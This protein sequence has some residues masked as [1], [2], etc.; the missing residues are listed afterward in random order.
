MIAE[1]RNVQIEKIHLRYWVKLLDVIQRFKMVS[2]K[3]MYILQNEYTG[4]NINKKFTTSVYDDMLK[5]K[6]HQCPK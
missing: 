5:Q 6:I 1:I 4:N 3:C 2:N